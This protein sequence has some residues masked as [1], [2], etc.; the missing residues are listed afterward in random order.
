VIG[1]VQTELQPTH[2]VVPL[3]TLMSIGDLHLRQ[4]SDVRF[5]GTSRGTFGCL[6]ADIRANL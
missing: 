5:G 2:Q 6:E 4:V 3:F 1:D